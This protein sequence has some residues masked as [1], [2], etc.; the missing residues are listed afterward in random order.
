MAVIAVIFGRFIRKL[1]KN[2]QNFTAS[3]NSIVE[4]SLTEYQM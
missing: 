3:A 1:S 4:E 2:A